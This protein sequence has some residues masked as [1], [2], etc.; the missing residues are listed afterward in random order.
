MGAWP[1]A[2]EYAMLR[3]LVAFPGPVSRCL[4]AAGFF[5]AGLALWSLAPLR[6]AGAGLGVALLG[7]LSLWV[8]TQTTAPGGATPAHEEVWAPVEEEWT[9]R[10]SALESKGADWDATPWDATSRVGCTGLGLVAL[11][12]AAVS[13]AALIWLGADAGLRLAGSSAVLFFPFWFNGIRTVWHPSELRL[14]GEALELGRGEAAAAAPGEYDAVPMLALRE[15]KR[16]KYPVDARVMLRPSREDGSRFLGIQ[17][18]VAI[19]SVRGTDYPYLYAVILGKEP[20]RFEARGLR[21]VVDGVRLVHERGDGE[22]VR[23][24]VVRQHADREGG[25][26]TGPEAIRAIVRAA[27]DVAL[28]ARKDNRGAV[29]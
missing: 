9:Q 2:A 7:H 16:G 19:N 11:G 24:L 17:L 6:W 8:R 14:K 20:F 18:Q 22:G 1:T 26:H 15:G 28:R 12:T 13:L 3:F 21:G 27:V 4:W 23:Y 5:L 25:W 29:R 10:V